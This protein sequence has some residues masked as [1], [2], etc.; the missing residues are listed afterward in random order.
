MQ[1]IPKIGTKET[2]E[3]TYSGK[4][5][6]ID[7]TKISFISCFMN[8]KILFYISS[9]PSHIGHFKDEVIQ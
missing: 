8:I 7:A 4:T 5:S 1:L 9:S 3:Y 6:L 2:N